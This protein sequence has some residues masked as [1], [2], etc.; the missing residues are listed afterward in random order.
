MNRSSKRGILLVTVV[1][2]SISLILIP[3]NAHAEEI[4]V[5]S[6]GLDKTTIM[7]LTNIGT[8]DVQTF[9]IWLSQNANFE[10]FKTEKGWI[11]EKTPQGVIIFTSSEPIKNNESVKFGIKTDKSSPIIN[12]KGLD[13]S[14]SVIDTGVT[15]TSIIKAVNQNPEIKSE[16]NI[17]NSGEILSESTFKIIPSKPNSGSTIRVTGDQFGALQVFDF[18]I[19]NEKIGILKIEV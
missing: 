12:W 3:S 2:F 9:R 7:T 6:L 17:P 14:D 10:S 19:D 4:N 13:Q 1:L 11:G 18:Y 15:T 16:Q 5:K 8:E